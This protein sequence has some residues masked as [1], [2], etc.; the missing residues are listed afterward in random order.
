M[1]IGDEALVVEECEVSEYQ[2][3]WWKS[4]EGKFK[5]KKSWTV[6]LA[7]VVGVASLKARQTKHRR[8]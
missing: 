7:S 1:K 4:S 2:I 3:A 5:N 8:R 6:S